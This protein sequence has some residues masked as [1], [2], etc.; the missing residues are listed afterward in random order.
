M[1]MRMHFVMVGSFNV[2]L[3]RC[4]NLKTN[5]EYLKILLQKAT[6]GIYLWSKDHSDV[7]FAISVFASSDSHKRNNIFCFH[8][9]RNCY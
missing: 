6:S 7:I 5:K 9:C 8:G 1:A 4:V 3:R 2:F